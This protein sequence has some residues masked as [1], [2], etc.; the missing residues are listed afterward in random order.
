MSWNLLHTHRMRGEKVLE[1]SI[2][3]NEFVIDNHGE[4]DIQNDIVVDGQSQ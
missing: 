2:A 1:D 3:T 4:M